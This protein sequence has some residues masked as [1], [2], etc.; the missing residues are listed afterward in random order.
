MKVKT[1]K[2]YKE[3]KKGLPNYS[4][5]TVG[6]GMEFKVGNDE[7][8][9]LQEAWE[10]INREITIQADST[11]P[12]WIAQRELKDGYKVTIKVPKKAENKGGENV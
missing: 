12:N 11:D 8:A 9:D 2:L 1:I 4:N 10:I 5:L 6:M 3:F 7:Q